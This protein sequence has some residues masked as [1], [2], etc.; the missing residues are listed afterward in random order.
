MRQ[1]TVIVTL[2][3]GAALSLAVPARADEQADARK[4]KLT[5]A[6]HWWEATANLPETG[7]YWEYEQINAASR[8]LLDA[9]RDL[10]ASKAERIA[11]IKAHVERM[12]QHYHKIHALFEKQARGGEPESNYCAEYWMLQA[13]VWLAEEQ[14]RP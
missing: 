5:A 14:A 8:A 11:A 10:A 2:A 9:E 1:R 7:K 12:T 3:V 4:Q 6:K 13:K